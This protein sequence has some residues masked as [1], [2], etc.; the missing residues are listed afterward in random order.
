MPHIKKTYRKSKY[1]LRLYECES[2]LHC[3]LNGDVHIIAKMWRPKS[4]VD[5]VIRMVVGVSLR[6]RDNNEY[7]D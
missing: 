2:D 4:I 6:V 7:V 3:L 1:K 5:E